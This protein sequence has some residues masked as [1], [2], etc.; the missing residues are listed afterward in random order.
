MQW[1]LDRLSGYDAGGLYL[2]PAHLGGIYRPGPVY[3]LSEGVDYSAHH[4]PA[5]RDFDYA[6]G[7][8]YR[9]ALFDGVVLAEDGDAD[10]VLF[11]VQ[12]HPEDGAREFDQLAGHRLLKA[13]Y[14]RYA[15]A[16]RYDRADFLYIYLFLKTFYLGFNKL[17]YLF[18]LYH[19]KLPLP[20]FFL[21]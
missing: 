7:P 10:I 16:D 19:I 8:L 2:D 11:E 3:G 1:L 18:Y 9:V 21:S 15:V 5:D 6:S 13:V 12:Y 20:V 14:P 17:A 4:R